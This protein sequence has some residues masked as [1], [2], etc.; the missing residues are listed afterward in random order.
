MADYNYE[1]IKE[2]LKSQE[3]ERKEAEK[4]NAKAMKQ[5]TKIEKIENQLRKEQEKLK[6]IIEENQSPNSSKKA[7]N[8]EI[9][10]QIIP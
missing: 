4:R 8:S 10:L 5:I 9:A 2:K 1:D 6:A 7:K 3:Q